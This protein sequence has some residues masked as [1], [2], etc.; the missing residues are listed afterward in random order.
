MQANPALN[1]KKNSGKKFEK[2]WIKLVRPN[3]G[4]FNQLFTF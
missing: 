2:N 3:L 1:L 4:L